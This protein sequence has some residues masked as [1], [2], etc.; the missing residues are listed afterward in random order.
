MLL[1]STLANVIQVETT[2][3]EIVALPLPLAREIRVLDPSVPLQS[4]SVPYDP[5]MMVTKISLID[6]HYVD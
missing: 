4:I 5:L 2:D 6:R 3:H 1:S